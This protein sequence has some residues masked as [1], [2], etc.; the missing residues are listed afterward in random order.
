MTEINVKSDATHEVC[1]SRVATIPNREGD[2]P[3]FIVVVDEDSLDIMV[4]VGVD[5][6]VDSLDAIMTA[7][8]MVNPTS[9]SVID[10]FR[11]RIVEPNRLNKENISLPLF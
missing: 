1:N 10:R 3:D 5:S 2:S 6:C 11:I 8:S 4:F 9:A 7:I